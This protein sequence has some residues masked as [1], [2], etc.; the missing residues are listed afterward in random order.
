[1]LN[2]PS[3]ADGT[4]PLAIGVA[5]ALEAMLTVSCCGGVQL[6]PVMV[7]LSPAFAVG[8]ATLMVGACATVKVPL[9]TATV[10]VDVEMAQI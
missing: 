8:V 10:L 3:L 9:E 6:A 1:M 2:V 4:C 5:L 7:T